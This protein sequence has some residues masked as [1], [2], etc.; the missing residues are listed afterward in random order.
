MATLPGLGAELPGEPHCACPLTEEPPDTRGG[1]LEGRTKT[2]H[3]SQQSEVPMS[4]LLRS[5]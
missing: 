5:C 2:E 1:G 4:F 3:E